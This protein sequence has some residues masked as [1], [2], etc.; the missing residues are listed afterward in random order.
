MADY[1]PQRELCRWST[2]STRRKIQERRNERLSLSHDHISSPVFEESK[3]S[4]CRVWA[5]ARVFVR[6][7]GQYRISC[8]RIRA[9]RADSRARN[10]TYCTALHSTALNCTVLYCTVLYCTVLYCTVLYCTVLHCT[11]RTV[12]YRTV[13]CT[14]LNCTVL[15]CTVLCCAVLCCAVL[16]CAALHCTALHCTVLGCTELHRAVLSCT[17]LY[18]IVPYSIVLYCAVLSCTVLVLIP[19]I[20]NVVTF[21]KGLKRHFHNYWARKR[22]PSRCNSRSIFCTKQILRSPFS[23]SIVVVRLGVYRVPSWI[24]ELDLQLTFVFAFSS[25][26]GRSNCNFEECKTKVTAG[27]NEDDYGKIENAWAAERNSI[28]ACVSCCRVMQMQI[29]LKEPKRKSAFWLTQTAEE[30]CS[31]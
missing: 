10:Y 19:D 16:R 3:F 14:A 25:L 26:F 24:Q 9:I 31:R 4:R 22:R 12:P 20:A 27:S 29:L 17:A 7:C 5:R 18:H 6:G 23:D 15:C 28:C 21:A 2:P 13:H 1:A 8:P 11:Y 30:T